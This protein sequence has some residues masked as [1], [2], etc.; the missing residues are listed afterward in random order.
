M[1][2]KVEI[3]TEQFK[4]II[5]LIGHLTDEELNNLIGEKRAGLLN[6]FYFERRAEAWKHE[7]PSK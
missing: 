1:I 3:T 4:A 6:S 2:D 7:K 5:E